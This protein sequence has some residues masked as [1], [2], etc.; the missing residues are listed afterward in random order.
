MADAN[1]A[2]GLSGPQRA[3][4]FLLGVGEES[5]TAVMKHLEP[6][7]VQLIGEA[8][9][10]LSSLTNEQVEG[11]MTDFKKRITRL[12]P[13]GLGAPDFTRRVLTHALGESRAKSML[14]KFMPGDASNSG[15]DALR[16][17]ESSAVTELI[18]DE[19]PQIIATVLVSLDDDHAAQVLR[20]LPTE[21]R[22]QVIYRIAR[23][24]QLEPSAMQELDAI[25][26]RQL[27]KKQSSPA[28][29]VDGKTSAAAIL[30]RMDDELEEELLGSLKQQNEELG[31]RV[32]EL[33]FVFDDL[34]ALDD[35]SMQRLIREISVDSLVIALKGV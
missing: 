18:Q 20:K 30:N 22:S 8:M 15:L 6:R 16:W 1:V 28:R 26:E 11:V 5:A 3:A 31:N 34:A 23:L 12:N 10:S 24:E 13:L 21:L 9:N 4:V 27:G 33:M 19:H 2:S 25:L 35:R 17:M 14:S 29:P 7:E 32:A